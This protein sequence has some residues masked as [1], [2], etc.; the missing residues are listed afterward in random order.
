VTVL[1]R[2]RRASARRA[3]LAGVV[4]AGA[5]APD[6][7]RGQVT[8]SLDVGGAT[9]AYDQ[10]LRSLV[11]TASPAVLLERGRATFL[12]RGAYSRFES[13]NESLQGT[14]AGSVLS[15]ALWKLRG[16]LGASA[17][18]TRYKTFTAATS[19]YAVGRVHLADASRGVWF[20][21][22]AGGVSQKSLFPDDMLQLE[23][24]GWVRARDVTFTG[25]LIPTWVGDT[26][27]TDA[28]AMMRWLGPEG[29]MTVLAG[30]RSGELGGGVN[31][32]MEFNGTVWVGRRLALVGGIGVF[33]AEITR[34]LP[35]GRYASAALRIASRRPTGADPSLVAQLILPYELRGLRRRMARAEEFVVATADDGTRNIRVLVPQARTVELMA[36]FTDW[37]PVPLTRERGGMWGLNIFIAPGVHRV[38]VRV[39]GGEWQPPPGLTTVP[40]GFGGLVGLL[41]VQ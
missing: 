31:R 12:A 26:A 22:A 39:D 33:P 16:E 4:G 18:T 10:F 3:V 6:A 24:G 37:A 2:R 38:S 11:A 40:D 20:G 1:S 21:T 17:S 25:Q 14:L 41:V 7:A 9:V 36:D 30:Y 27:Y 8:L 29:D 5:L 32:W 35:G 34:G 28:T 15:S 13:G 19:V 23:L